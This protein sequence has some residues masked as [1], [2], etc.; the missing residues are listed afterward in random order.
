MLFTS[1]VHKHP[2]SGQRLYSGTSFQC[3]GHHA[4]QEVL[5]MSA[6]NAPPLTQ[7][8]FDFQAGDAGSYLGKGP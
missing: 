5:S 3:V 4:V 2:P 7:I 8:P 6:I 1:A